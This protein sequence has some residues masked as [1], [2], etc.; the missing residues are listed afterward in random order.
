[1]HSFYCTE[2][3]QRIYYRTL[4]TFLFA[5]N[6]QD[7]EYWCTKAHLQGSLPPA[8][9][10]S[11]QFKSI[12]STFTL[13]GTWGSLWPCSVIFLMCYFAVDIYTKLK[14]LNERIYRE[15]GSSLSTYQSQNLCFP[16][17]LA[18]KQPL[19]ITSHLARDD[20][21]LH[22]CVCKILLLLPNSSIVDTS[23]STLPFSCNHKSQI[24]QY[25]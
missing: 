20:L 16:P 1:M 25:I 17:L 19:L 14:K 9:S 10:I 12:R 7:C 21:S 8:K 3:F 24:Y 22:K 5:E 13:L 4:M 15:K 23:F 18:S 2:T 6:S 11:P